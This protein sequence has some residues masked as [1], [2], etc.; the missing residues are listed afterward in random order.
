M[1]TL[2]D[3]P[4]TENA[5]FFDNSTLEVFQTCPRA[6]QYSYLGRRELATSK[7]ALNFGGAI[8]EAL[9]YRYANNLLTWEPDK[10][11]FIE[12][13]DPET[14][15]YSTLETTHEAAQQQILTDWFAAKPQPI[16]DFRTADYAAE[17]IRQYNELY[18][19]EQFSLLSTPD[20]HSLVEQPFIIKFGGLRT[21]VNHTTG[22]FL[23]VQP[24]YIGRIDLGATEYG[25][26]FPIDHKTSSIFGST[27]AD[28]QS[29]SAQHQGYA[30]AME[31]TMGF[32]PQRYMVNAIR[33][34]PPLKGGGPR[35]RPAED[36]ARHEFPLRP[37]QLEEW[38]FNVSSLL[39]EFFFHYN[40]GYMPM[41]T[42]WCVGKYGR[43]PYF[44][45][46]GVPPDQRNTVLTSSMFD[47]KD[48]SPLNREGGATLKGP[49]PESVAWQNS[50]LSD[51]L[52][53]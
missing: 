33:T 30:W 16:D 12:V 3:L 6:C 9:R 39:D 37:G 43:C 34:R 29:M 32:T 51:I 26:R 42:K 48:W 20:G 27:M 13:K 5:I 1:T 2:P 17:I 49:S 53:G 4:L 15:K 21:V 7:P 8:H 28:E 35:V 14:G 19:H 25:Q 41:K 44:D 50:S 45:V 22:G 52:R 10:K 24:Y 40:R 23:E 46:C 11:I 31:K 18:S 38:E 36:F 47:V